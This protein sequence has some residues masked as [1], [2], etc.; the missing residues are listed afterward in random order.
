MDFVY[1]STMQYQF[2]ISAIYDIS[3]ILI[4]WD[5]L[6]NRIGPI[7]RQSR[8]FKYRKVVSIE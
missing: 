5:L 7:K 2:T 4:M 6:D 3:I 8:K 1:Y